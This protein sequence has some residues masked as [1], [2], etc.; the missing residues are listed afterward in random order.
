MAIKLIPYDSVVKCT[1]HTGSVEESVDVD[2]FG[3]VWRIVIWEKKRGFGGKA[4]KKNTTRTLAPNK[5]LTN[6]STIRTMCCVHR[7]LSWPHAKLSYMCFCLPLAPL[8]IYQLNEAMR[9][10]FFETTTGKMAQLK[11]L[12]TQVW[13]ET[14]PLDFL[15]FLWC[16]YNKVNQ[17]LLMLITT[18]WLRLPK[19][20]VETTAE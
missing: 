1:N 14:P 10:R 12:E 18:D 11:R 3:E 15:E 2:M 20:I 9:C 8:L 4:M 7:V 16:S 6:I 17:W 19:N 13:L 5:R